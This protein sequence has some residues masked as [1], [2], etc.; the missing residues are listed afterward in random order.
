LP[1]N[2]SGKGG[3]SMSATINAL[4]LVKKN[5]RY[6]FLY[7]DENRVEIMRRM[8]Q[9]AS[10]PDLSFNWYDAAILTQKVRQTPEPQPSQIDWF[11]SPGDHL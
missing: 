8:G 6:I 7:D 4:A 3:I 11:L 9:F 1:F 5:E 10:D 2:H